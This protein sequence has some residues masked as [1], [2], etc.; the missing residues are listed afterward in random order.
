[1]KNNSSQLNAE[2]KYIVMPLDHLGLLIGNY[3]YE[4]GALDKE[5]DR[6]EYITVPV[7]IDDE[8]NITLK[9]GIQTIT[10]KEL[11]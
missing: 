1:M 11:N 5:S 7:E 9:V 2:P 8:S 6:L 3:L 4:V 10:Q